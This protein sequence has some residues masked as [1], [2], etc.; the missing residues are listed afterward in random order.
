MSKIASALSLVVLLSTVSCGDDDKP[1]VL[2]GSADVGV[3]GDVGGGS[4]VA[5][6]ADGG[7]SDGATATMCTGTFSALNR[8]QLGA[9]TMPAGMCASASDLNLICTNNIRDL[10]AACGKNSCLGMG[11]SCINACLKPQVALSDPCLG[12]YSAAV[13]CVESKCLGECLPDPSAPGCTQCQIQQGCLR[14]FFACSGLPSGAPS[15]DGGAGD[16]AGSPDGGTGDATGDTATAT[17]DTG[18]SDDGAAGN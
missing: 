9:L 13:I 12:C 8:A 7:G 5:S 14:D 1:K 4:D 16:A 2:D 6:A 3:G 15:S 11:A 10:A 17:P 18:S